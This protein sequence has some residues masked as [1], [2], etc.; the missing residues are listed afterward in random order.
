MCLDGIEGGIEGWDW[1]EYVCFGAYD[2]VVLML[3]DA[4]SE[5]RVV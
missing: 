1:K 5:G 2:K 3:R 4:R